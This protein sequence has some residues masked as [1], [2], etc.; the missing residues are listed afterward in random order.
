MWQMRTRL[1][2]CRVRVTARLKRLGLTPIVEPDSGP[3]LWCRLPDG[4]DATRVARGALAHGVILAPGNLFSAD[5]AADCLRFNVA[6]MEDEAVFR[7]LAEAQALA[8]P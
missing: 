1:D 5:D 2:Q 7:L 8:G 6:R 4:L 3:F